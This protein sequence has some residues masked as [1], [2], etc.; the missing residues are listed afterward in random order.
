MLQSF[1]RQSR[2]E[3]RGRLAFEFFEQIGQPVLDRLERLQQL[4]L[5]DAF[6]I[7]LLHADG[8]E[9]PCIARSKNAS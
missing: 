5:G 7:G 6:D 4:P 1:A 9:D 2:P 8:A 3:L